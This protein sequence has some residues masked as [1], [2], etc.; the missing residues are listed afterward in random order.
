M[1][2]DVLTLALKIMALWCIAS[3]LVAFGFALGR[4]IG[5]NQ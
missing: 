3:V 4:G 2:A 5:R 1:P